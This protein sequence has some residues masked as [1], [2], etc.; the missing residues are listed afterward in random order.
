MN[1]PHAWVEEHGDYL[2]RYCL[3]HFRDE[4]VAEDL[5][6]ETFLGALKS[7]GAFE[8]RAQVRTWLTSILRNK[9]IDRIRQKQR[10]REIP[11][12]DSQGKDLSQFFDDV[13]HWIADVGPRE[14]NLS[15]ETALENRQFMVAVEECLGKLPEKLRTVFVLREVDDRD[16]N[17]IA[18]QLSITGNNVGVMLH[19]A[20]L[21]L[22]DCLQ[23]NW[24]RGAQR[25]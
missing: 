16:R 23:G 20:R 12:E 1:E 25:T 14:W 3:R 4:A 8:G 5:V 13:E 21:L 9:I 10:H 17:E 2:F 18:E 6:Q 22:R 7:Q 19:R 24:F 15:P 11:I